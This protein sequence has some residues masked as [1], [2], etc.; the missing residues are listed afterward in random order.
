MYV[1]VRRSHLYSAFDFLYVLLML[2]LLLFFFCFIIAIQGCELLIPW[3]RSTSFI[4]CCRIDSNITACH[5]GGS[6]LFSCFL[7]CVTLT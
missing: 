7:W 5:R 6:L 2:L 4:Y 3:K 1:H